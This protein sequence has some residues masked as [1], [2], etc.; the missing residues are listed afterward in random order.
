MVFFTGM[1]SKQAS[2]PWNLLDVFLGVVLVALGT[3]LVRVLL[4]GD[5]PLIGLDRNLA[6]STGI[7]LVE[8]FLF[9]AVL[10]LAVYKYKSKWRVVG[11][12]QDYHPRYYWI[13]LA[14]VVV[15]LA[16]NGLYAFIVSQFGWKDLEPPGVPTTLIGT[17]LYRIFNVAVIGV[18]GPLAEELFFR[19]FL[20][21]AL[22]PRFKV[23][24]AVVIS[25]A[26]FSISHG[27]FAVAIPILI[28]GL[29]LALLYVKSKSIWPSVTTHSA[30]NL[31]ALAFAGYL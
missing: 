6:N 14:A 31:L 19:G 17:G 13:A 18:W 27:S 4:F 8:S 12:H 15:I 30:Q 26:M 9:L 5:E 23:G 29:I 24:G 20:L 10:V 11:L 1:E 3:I 7:F 21:P 2:V 22:I 25:S 16:S 28:S